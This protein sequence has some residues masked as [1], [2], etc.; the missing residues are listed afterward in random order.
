[1][2]YGFNDAHETI[3]DY[4]LQYIKIPAQSSMLQNTEKY[5]RNKSKYSEK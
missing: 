5:K 4:F 1:M 3:P 2:D